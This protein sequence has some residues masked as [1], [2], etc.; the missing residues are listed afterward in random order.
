MLNFSIILI[1]NTL[2]TLGFV[3]PNVLQTI[4]LLLLYLSAGV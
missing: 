1:E 4:V 2:H 3:M